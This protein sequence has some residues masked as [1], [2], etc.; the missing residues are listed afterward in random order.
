[1]DNMSV[2]EFNQLTTADLT[3]D[4]VY[5]AG[6]TGNINDDPLSRLLPGIGNQGGF[7]TCG[8]FI[9]DSVRF[10]VLYT[11]SAELDWPDTL[12]SNTRTF[13]Y[14]GDNRSP[15]RSLYDTPKK[16]NLLLSRVFQR[17]R[18]GRSGRIQVPPFL[19]FDKVG[20]GRDVRFAGVLA[21]GSNLMDEEEDLTVV[22]RTKDGQRF[23]NYRATFTI[24]NIATVPRS[25]IDQLIASE[26]L[27]TSCPVP[28]R[29]WVESGSYMPA[30]QH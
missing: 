4:C 23:Q 28:W 18:S 11:S 29:S 1:M 2:V 9:K 30:N 25:W 19:L 17:V 15:G 10:T 21:P 5:K 26:P 6:R 24:L 27:G 20:T 16:G 14:F 3:V 22:S 7:R 13:T 12:D 8:S